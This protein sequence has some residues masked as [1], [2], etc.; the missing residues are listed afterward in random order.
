MRNLTKLEY[1]D[2]S[3]NQLEGDISLLRYLS[4]MVSLQLTANLFT[5]IVPTG[6]WGLPKMVT[7]DVTYNQFEGPI[8][9]DIIN[10]KEIRRLSTTENQ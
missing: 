7:I 2:V 10:A 4:N 8:T 3:R 6:I 9:S 1:L 5:G